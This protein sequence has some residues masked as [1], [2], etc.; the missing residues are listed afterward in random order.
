MK[1][2]GG[3]VGYQSDGGAWRSARLQC[4]PKGVGRAENRSEI[5]TDHS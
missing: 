1:V 3:G 2:L 4:G 5:T